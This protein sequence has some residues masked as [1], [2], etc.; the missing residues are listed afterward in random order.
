MWKPVVKS[1]FF[2]LTELFVFC[3]FIIAISYLLFPKGK[4]ERFIIDYKGPNIEL[5][6]MYLENLIRINPDPNLKLLLA[7]RYIQLGNIEKSE[8][9]LR[10]IEDT[11]L[12]HKAKYLR[13]TLLKRL[14]FS[15]E[16]TN[17]KE[18]L[19]REMEKLLSE[20]MEESESLELLESIYKEAVSMAFHEIALNTS[21]KI[22][23]ILKNRDV[24][25]L[26]IV[27]KH[28]LELRRHEIA[29]RYGTLLYELDR[30]N[31][32]YWLKQLYTV[33]V[34]FG[35]ES[36]AVKTA[37]LLSKIEPNN[38]EKYIQD[39]VFILSKREDYESIIN[40]LL[41]IY[42]E[43]RFTLNEVLAQIYFVKK[44]YTRAFRIYYSIY[45]SLESYNL[46]KS[47]YKKII[48]LL[49]ASNQYNILKEFLLENY[50]E[51]IQDQETAK[52]SLKAAISTGDTNLSHKIAKNIKGFI[53]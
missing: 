22:S 49:L 36:E 27:F 13:Y 12:K 44:D 43:D 47:M 3:F 15:A 39:M 16:S 52:L 41:K 17:R 23:S 19:Y 26:K 18:S 34:A 1:K 50:L 32:I 20:S 53:Q 21:L 25:W 38:R 6:N 46:R 7:Q 10:E 31:Y 5:A 2:D 9:I 48:T 8:K 30:E 29:V 14:Y 45:A 40:S 35:L 42:P 4:L 33:S 11:P 51:Y 24:N 28:S 37:I